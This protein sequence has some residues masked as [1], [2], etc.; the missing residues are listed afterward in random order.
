MGVCYN[1]GPRKCPKWTPKSGNPDPRKVTLNPKPETLNPKPEGAPK[2]RKP[3]EPELKRGEVAPEVLAQ[4]TY[5][6]SRSASLS[7][8]LGFGA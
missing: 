6:S 8:G 4:Q 5:D 1:R 7:K 2:F 3:S